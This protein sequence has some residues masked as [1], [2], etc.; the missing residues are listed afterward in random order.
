M[1]HTRPKQSERVLDYMNTYGGITQL[2]ALKELGVFRLAS[3]ISELKK[4]GY[5][6]TSQMVKV[7]NRFG[8]KC[9]VKRYRIAAEETDGR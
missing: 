5:K 8:E 6:I 4:K 7:E 9:R 1:A 3:R 2:E